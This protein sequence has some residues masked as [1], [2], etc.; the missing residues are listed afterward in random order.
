MYVHGPLH[1]KRESGV[2]YF[3]QL[4][5]ET[6]KEHMAEEKRVGGEVWPAKRNQQLHGDVSEEEK[7]CAD[8]CACGM[9]NG[10]S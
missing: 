6:L 4:V 3:K 8:V 2:L 7:F 9:K 1:V 10:C 5:Q